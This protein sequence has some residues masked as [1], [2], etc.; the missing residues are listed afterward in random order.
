MTTLTTRMTTEHAAMILRRKPSSAGEREL[1][2]TAIRT[3]LDAG[4]DRRAIE[5][6]GMTVLGEGEL[7]G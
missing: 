3:L 1:R 6:E 5:I 2:A 7:E 4:Y